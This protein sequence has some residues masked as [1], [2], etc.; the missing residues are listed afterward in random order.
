M[1]VHR[2]DC[3]SLAALASRHPERVIEVQW[4]TAGGQRFEVRVRVEAYDRQGLLRDVGAVL[5]AAQI[6]VLQLNSSA[7]KDGS[8]TVEIDLAVNDFAQ[9]SDLL[10]RL[11]ALPN[12]IDAQRLG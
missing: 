8:A 9:L 6:S 11:R 10:G 1:R 12:V 3:G 5:A 4:G 7:A 2:A